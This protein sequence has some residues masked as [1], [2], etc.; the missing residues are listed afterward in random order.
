MNAQNPSTVKELWEAYRL[1]IDEFQDNPTHKNKQ[2][3]IFAH[4]CWAEAFL[5]EAE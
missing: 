4:E 2:V 1:A 3:A 5:S